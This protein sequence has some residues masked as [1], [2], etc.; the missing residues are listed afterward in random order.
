M[1]EQA[2]AGGGPQLNTTH[3]LV[4]YFIISGYVALGTCSACSDT[5][6]ASGLTN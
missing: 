5:Q 2:R 1:A 3:V 6:P 4:T